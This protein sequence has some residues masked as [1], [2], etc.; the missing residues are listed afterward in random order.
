[1]EKTRTS[2]ATH[3]FTFTPLSAGENGVS[4]TCH[5]LT[6]QDS[7]NGTIVVPMDVAEAWL[8]AITGSP[9]E[10]TTEQRWCRARVRK[11]GSEGAFISR[12]FE[13]TVT[14]Q[15]SHHV[16]EQELI[17]GIRALGWETHHIISHS[18]RRSTL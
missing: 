9:A 7:M 1:M 13:I 6:Q 14:I 8:R 15:G 11:E 5:P 18:I 16:L 17:A 3:T 10:V 12:D 2:T 4:I